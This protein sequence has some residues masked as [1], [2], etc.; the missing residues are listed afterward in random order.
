M[1]Y[2]V[3]VGLF[4]LAS[5]CFWRFTEMSE[6]LRIIA[7]SRPTFT[8]EVEVNDLGDLDVYHA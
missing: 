4:Q 5:E 1:H 7:R 2:E 3:I 6:C 8:A